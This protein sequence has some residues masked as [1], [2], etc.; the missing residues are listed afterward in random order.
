MIPRLMKFISETLQAIV[1]AG[2]IFLFVYL[3]LAQP[4]KISGAS[5][6]PN[7]I[8]NEYLLTNK[9]SYRLREPERGEVVV[10]EAPPNGEK[11]FIKRIIALPGET[12]R[13]SGNRVFVNGVELVE[14]YLPLGTETRSTSFFPENQVV[15]VPENSYFVLGDNRDHSLDSRTFGF[16]KKDSITGKAWFVY[17]PPQLAGSVD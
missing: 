7:F 6:E 8:D 17:W 3:L 13:I 10:F 11:D 1:F 16:I 2:A 14:P 9:V 15:A 4:H 5:M 12:V